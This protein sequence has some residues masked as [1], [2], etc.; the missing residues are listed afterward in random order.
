MPNI[1]RPLDDHRYHVQ[2]VG[3]AAMLLN[4]IADGGAGGLSVTEIADR[5]GVAKSTALALAR[6]LASAGLLRSVD[7]GPRYVLGLN[8]LR[9]G[10]LVGQQTSIGELGLPT[11]RDLS[12]VT[13]M[14]ARL[15]SNESGYPVFIERIDGEGSIRFHAPLGQREQPH[16]TAAGKAILAHLSEAN[17]RELL[18]EAGMTRYTPKTLTDIE[19]LLAELDRVR[20]EGY[21]LDDEE[22]AEGVF[23][24][25]SAFFDHQG[26]CAGALSVTGLKVDVALREVQQLGVTVREHADRVSSMLGGRRPLVVA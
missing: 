17:V 20:S 15:A 23:C 22:E 24:V 9:L 3:R 10:D 16:A 8:L 12:A 21:A 2:S 14:T 7:P 1:V 25:G 6:T 4:E 26:V 5:L 13:G 11:L 18:G 19:S